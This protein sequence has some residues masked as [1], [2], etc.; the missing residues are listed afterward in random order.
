MKLPLCINGFEYEACFDD[1]FVETAL[2][3]LLRHLTDMHRHAG[4]RL[5]VLLAAPPGTG[6]STLAAALE[7]LSE[8]TPDCARVQAVGLDGFHYPQKILIERGLVS[9]KGAPHTFD[10]EALCAKLED[11]A[12]RD[13]LWP[14]YDRRLHDVVPD[15]IPVTAPV[16]MVEGNWL[17]LNR[18][19]WTSLPRDLSVFIQ[20]DASNLRRRLIDRKLRG[21]LSLEAAEAFV[22]N[23]DIPN[24]HT[25]LQESLTGD[26][27]WKMDADGRYTFAI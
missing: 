6:K 27:R 25:C 24:V 21:G 18:E 9:V 19:P 12:T 3:P 1:A 26:V 23:S 16:L 11:A 7:H 5:I 14:L 4:R 20:A 15:A 22:E 10:A 17:L 8:V 13:V 2:R